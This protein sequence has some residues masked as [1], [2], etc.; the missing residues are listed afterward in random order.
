VFPPEAPLFFLY[1][2]SS[3]LLI[4][5]F[6]VLEDWV[7]VVLALMAHACDPSYLGDLKREDH[8]SK[9]AQS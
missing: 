2:T 8:G 3:P 4:L 9:P 7:I 1:S 6:P 5:A